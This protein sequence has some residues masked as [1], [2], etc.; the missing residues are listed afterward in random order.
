M[1]L[2]YILHLVTD[3]GRVEEGLAVCSHRVHD[4]INRVLESHVQTSIY[5]VDDH[6]A[7]VGAVESGSLFHVLE[8]A[9][10]S[11]DENVH[12][13]DAFLLFLTN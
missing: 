5:F 3:R 8:K 6:H 4:H 7:H 10:G 1:K 11:A 13:H 2:R 12:G 9:S